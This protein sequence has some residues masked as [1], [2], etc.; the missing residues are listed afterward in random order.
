[1]AMPFVAPINYVRAKENRP[2]RFAY[3][4]GS[5]DPGMFAPAP[6]RSRPKRAPKR[7]IA[8][9]IPLPESAEIGTAHSD[10]HVLGVN[11]LAL[12]LGSIDGTQ[13][14]GGIL[15]SGGRDGVVKAWDLNLP[16]KRSRKETVDDGDIDSSSTP[17]AG[18]AIDR[19][20]VRCDCP[21]TSLRASRA[22]H[23]DWVND[24]ILVNDSKTI[25]SA[26]S[27]LTVRAWTPLGSCTR[28]STVGSHLD[29]VKA[30][31]YSS[32]RQMVISG[33]L[34]RKIKLWD[35]GEGRP[36]DSPICALQEVGDASVSSSVYTLACNPQGTLVVSGSPEKFIRI[37][38]TRTAKQ[39]TTLSG[40]TDHIR[41]VLMSADS[42]FILS[43]S[44]DTTVKLWSMR[45]RRCLST[46]SHHTN[47]VWSLHS[48]HPRF[49]TFYSA[50]RDGLVA[51]TMG[52]GMHSEDGPPTRRAS[53]APA[54]W[55]A[56]TT[57]ALAAA[58]TKSTT[59]AHHETEPAAVVEDA[60][61][62][63]GVVCVAI[64]KEA[65]GV[66]KLVAA[67]DAY[68]WTATKGPALNRWKDV[69]GRKQHVVRQLGAS[70][71]GQKS[72][73]AAVHAQPIP[74]RGDASPARASTKSAEGST[75]GSD[76]FG[77][78]T[79]SSLIEPLQAFI[80][81]DSSAAASASAA[82]QINGG[83][84]TG[85]TQSQ[86]Y[87]IRRDS[88]KPNGG[89]MHRRNQTVDHSAPYALALRNTASPVLKAMQAEQARRSVI[90][91]SDSEDL[92]E[93]ARTSPDNSGSD[94]AS[95]ADSARSST[96]HLHH[97][98]S[99]STGLGQ[100][101]AL[102]SISAMFAKERS[103]ST[104]PHSILGKS[105]TSAL[106]GDTYERLTAGEDDSISIA[107]SPLPSSSLIDANA[108][109]SP[110]TAAAAAIAIAGGIRSSPLNYSLY[111]KGYAKG[112]PSTQMNLDDGHEIIPV[113]SKPD[114]TIHGKHGL[115]RHKI[116]PNKRQVLAQ[117]TQGRV[118]LWDIMLCRRVYEFPATE[119]EARDCKQFNGIFGK[120][121]D[122]IESA[123]STCPESVNAWCRVD[124]RIGALTVRLDESQVWSAE[125]H[126]DEIDGITPET[127]RA[128]G[129]HE[130]VNIGQ[131][132][133]KRLFLNYARARVK[134]GPISAQDATRLNYWAAQIPTAEV[135]PAKAAAQPLPSPYS[136]TEGQKTAT[137]HTA[138][139]R[140]PA[141][142]GSSPSPPSAPGF[143]PSNSELGIGE[144]QLQLQ[145][146]QRFP[147]IA[148]Q[149]MNSTEEIGI[150]DLSSKAMEAPFSARPAKDK[151]SSPDLA[152]Q[153]QD[154]M[155][156]GLRK[157][158]GG[159]HS[160]DAD[161]TDRDG[162]H[163]EYA[164]ETNAK[165]KPAIGA[166]TQPRHQ[167]NV[168]I[169]T[170]PG[171]P[172]GATAQQQQ[173]A[174]GR[175]EDGE[176][177]S[178]NGSSGKFM[179]RLRS[180][181]VRKQKSIGITQTNAGP[182]SNKSTLASNGN[183]N[184]S[185]HPP[186]PTTNKSNSTP[187]T[188]VNG[189]NAAASI[190]GSQDR[191]GDA[192][193]AKPERDEFAEWAGPRFPT[194]TERT[195]A[196]LQCTP[197][198]WDQLYSPVVCPRLP[199]PRNVI[200]Q[201]CQE[202]VDASEPYSI[203]RNTIEHIAGFPEQQRNSMATFRINDDPL[204]SFEM[205]MPA[206]L[207][208]FL[209]FNRL[210]ASYQEPAK[211]SFVLSP[212][213]GST[214]PPFPNPNARLVANGMLRA[215]KLAIYVADKLGLPLMQQPALN[216][217]NAVDACVRAYKKKT[218]SGE[219]LADVTYSNNTYIDVFMRAGEELSEEEREALDD[220]LSWRTSTISKGS[221]DSR[222]EYVGRPELYLDLFSKEVKVKPRQ[223]LATIKANV[224]KA[225]GDI[226]VY[227][228]WASFVKKR[229][230]VAQGL[231]A[232]E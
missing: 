123:L 184:S 93:D 231:A 115:H 100:D 43:G 149:L 90:K 14:T 34:D 211:V 143:L 30:L 147:A 11:A 132:M 61:S 21:K 7:S 156:G 196:L 212:L 1:M 29:Y 96:N 148:S 105:S 180:I 19:H 142:A 182:G 124:T 227:Y 64:A 181:R 75:S 12:S 225:S 200:V 20:K 176:S 197:A 102:G 13:P 127:M 140:L 18:W 165:P 230:L 39:L 8:Y 56:A 32:H 16:L 80:F 187:D 119:G 210:P 139:T 37:W 26:S 87:H 144:K 69:G 198:P 91:E 65:H 38:D 117:D 94:V 62:S 74:G 161:L 164:N 78:V 129:D 99:R 170:A 5:V 216:Y 23:S 28:P 86:Q 44:S 71:S 116:L 201:I 214:L 224:W 108:T 159:S 82:V 42:E 229:V 223:T 226:Q 36:R 157:D 179:S 52:A 10:G 154:A 95:I 51:K 133:L 60:L 66:V 54:P 199:L 177:A 131:W 48:T 101:K 186:L 15:F 174:L 221:S 107:D 162:G 134:R 155:G 232:K 45:M 24:I 166:P 17:A 59:S 202:H 203:Y 194:D 205:G 120:D 189:A 172:Q 160:S 183:S 97:A 193:N 22:L 92:F 2:H 25:V 4:Y 63:V 9:T 27:D 173:Q 40:H 145:P 73:T 50:S 33:G 167:H 47:S 112:L 190:N 128:M 220:M 81:D 130:R 146:Q 114:E 178:S 126:V 171:T 141:L 84:H 118:S 67:D 215:R 72:G 122:R 151:P 192:P 41:S 31:A 113:R 169:D 103:P 106:K 153:V 207:A 85:G 206:W 3:D 57:T 152:K 76:E 70:A 77:S 109:T 222:V 175:G 135:I 89:G 150:G 219:T 58:A 188:R 83:N 88:A 191:A 111:N 125:V 228:E 163:G 110:V 35:I 104:Q 138:A 53:L 6:E 68:I 195:L 136:A 46:Y 137:A 55:S 204:L 158:S 121:F 79:R 208:D 168:S 217:T 213:Q 98:R 218:L 209:L 49:H 185:L